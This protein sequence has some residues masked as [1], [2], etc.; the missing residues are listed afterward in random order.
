MTRMVFFF[1][2][3]HYFSRGISIEMDTINDLLSTIHTYLK[4][5]IGILSR[6]RIQRLSIRRVITFSGAEV[7]SS[8]YLTFV[9]MAS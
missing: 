2:V 4:W 1:H 7:N 8:W 6:N 9:R 5:I 3:G